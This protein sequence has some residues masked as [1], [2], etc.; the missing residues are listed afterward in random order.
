MNL[1]L[2]LKSTKKLPPKLVEIAFRVITNIEAFT[3][4]SESSDGFYVNLREWKK[5]HIEYYKQRSIQSALISK[6]MEKG[7]PKCL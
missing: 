6:K 7:A 1:R 2:D 4:A 3:R 5:N